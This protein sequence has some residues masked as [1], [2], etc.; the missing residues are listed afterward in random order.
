MRPTPPTR[1]PRIIRYVFHRTVR[2]R[3]CG[4]WSLFVSAD[5]VRWTLYRLGKHYGSEFIVERDAAVGFFLADRLRAAAMAR[6]TRWRSPTTAAHMRRMRRT[7]HSLWTTGTLI[8]RGAGGSNRTEVRRSVAMSLSLVSGTSQTFQVAADCCAAGP[9]DYKRLGLSGFAGRY[10]ARDVS[11]PATGNTGDLPSWSYCRAFN[12]NECIEGSSAGSLYMS[13]PM[14]DLTS[15]CASSQFTQAIPCLYQPAP[16]SG[17]SIQFRIDRGDFSGLTTR[18]FG[19][20]NGHPGTAYEYSNCRPTADAQF[21]FCPGYWLDG[22]RVEWLAYRIPP[23]IPSGQR[24]SH[25]VRASH[26]D[27]PRRVVRQ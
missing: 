1:G 16:W 26:V 13:L 24:E 12:A 5:V 6:A 2:R 22:V 14:V 19:Y 7:R 15:Q 27:L 3:R 4:H 25:V 9:S 18:K 10:L 8:H 11:S 23:R 20:V 21:M 17:Q